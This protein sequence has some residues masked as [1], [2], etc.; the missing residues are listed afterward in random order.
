MYLQYRPGMY[1]FL[2]KLADKF[3]LVLFNTASLAFTEAI[4]AQIKEDAPNNRNYFSY[5]L[6]KEHCS[7]DENNQEIK[8]LAFFTN[9]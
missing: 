1:Q 8:N 2:E 3:E 9:D 6:G 7:V 4:V 5:V